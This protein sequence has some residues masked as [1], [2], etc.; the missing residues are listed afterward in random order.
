[1]LRVRLDQTLSSNHNQAGDAFSATVE[2]PLIVRGETVIKRGATASGTVIDAR[3][4]GRIK[5]AAVLSIR[6]DRVRAGGRSYLISTSSIE[7]VEQGKGKRSAELAGLALASAPSSEASL[8]G[9]RALSSV[10]S[11]A[12]EQVQPGEP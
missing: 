11:Q 5:G 3:G 1:M 7:R 8:A 2:S 12:Q 4:Q 10:A 6:L 9:A